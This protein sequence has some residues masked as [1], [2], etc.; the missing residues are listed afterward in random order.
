M[1]ECFTAVN[2][3]SGRIA[4]GSIYGA[5]LVNCRYGSRQQANMR[6]ASQFPALLLDVDDERLWRDGQ[7]VAL[8]P[9]TFGLLRYLVERRSRLVTKRVLLEGVWPGVRVVESEVK[10]YVAELR[11]AL[12][13]DPK[14]PRF[15]ETIRG[16]GYRFI[17][18]IAIADSQSAPRAS[19]G[20]L[21]APQ[22]TLVKETSGQP[23]GREAELGQLRD[24]FEK[25]LSG[26]RQICFIAGEP[27]IG[28]TT[29]ADAFRDGSGVQD[30]AWVARGECLERYGAEEPYMPVLEALEA[31]CGAPGG[32]RVTEC[33]GRYAPSW[34][35]QMPGLVEPAELESIERRTQGVTRDRMWRELAQFIEAL[36]AE[37]GLVLLIEDLHWADESTLGLIAYLAQRPQRAR[38]LLLGT[39]RPTEMCRSDSLQPFYGELQARGRCAVLPLPALSEATVAEHL[40][41]EFPSPG[42]LPLELARVI[43]RRAE[44]NPLFVTKILEHMVAQ[45]WLA[46]SD[47]Q[48]RL[49]VDLSTFELGIPDDVRELIEQ[50]LARLDIEDQRLLEACSVVGLAFSGKAAAAGLDQEPEAVEES[51]EA[52]ARRKLFIRRRATTASPGGQVAAQY[53]FLHVLC[54]RTIYERIPP[55]RRGRLHRLIG[56]QMER[57]YS[58][59]TQETAA[60]L[61][62]HFEQGCDFL[63]ASRYLGE[64]ADHALRLGSASEAVGIVEKANALLSALPENVE[65]KRQELALSLDLGAALTAVKGYGAAEVEQAYLRSRELCREMGDPPELFPALRGLAAFYVGRAK[66]EA[67]RELGEQLLALAGETGDDAHYLE[68]H[69]SLGA[70]FYFVGD[71]TSA[72]AHLEKAISRY[73]PARHHTHA[74]LYGQDPSVLALG[75]KAVILWYLGRPSQAMPI[76]GLALARSR[77]LAHRFSCALALCMSAYLHLMRREAQE[78]ERQAEATLSLASEHEFSY[79]SAEALIYRGWSLTEQSRGEEGIA[80]IRKGLAAFETTGAVAG[81]TAYLAILAQAYAHRGRNDEAMDVVQ[82]ALTLA[83]SIG[84][85][86]VAAELHRLQGELLL[87]QGQGQA[88]SA[89]ER[90]FRRALDIANHRGAKSLELR[91]AVSLARL[92]RDLGKRNDALELLEP[93]YGCFTEGFETLDLREAKDLLDLTRGAEE[94]DRREQRRRKS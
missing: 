36:T 37:R 11:K 72:L 15:I 20:P 74:A 17:G 24:R 70:T 31:L 16:R 85:H 2:T 42:G 64:A 92:W 91:A 75:F 88:V 8:T 30:A 69:L 9:K 94:N 44:G 56:E 77:E 73:D 25:A 66:Y 62:Y 39:S 58:K 35:L 63:R 22:F 76:D 79:L 14:A 89:A 84:E 90:C 52:L 19:A 23:S 65:R 46:Q 82:K 34:L 57:D 43:H 18:E 38:L 1:L 29:L 80:L 47:G 10:H 86:L 4:L 41:K 54:H 28:K 53:E 68:G 78:V 12:S 50:R 48:W 6:T 40:A 81:K 59:R 7:V 87:R 45:G 32:E 49:L 60:E 26:E 13:D 71:F 61:A 55:L 93:I 5:I 67:A 3:T 51:C 27:G 21:C 83:D 33:L